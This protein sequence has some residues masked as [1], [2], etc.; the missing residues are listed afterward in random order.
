MKAVVILIC[1][2]FAANTVAQEL[3]LATEQQ[4]ENLADADEAATED[5]S[6]LQELE[7]FRR[8]PLNLN[9]TD[10]VALR[11]LR[12]LNELQVN[13]LVVYRN[14]FGRFISVYELQAIP[15]WD[16]ITI[17]KLLPFITTAVPFI[18]KEEW[19]KRLKEGE[20]SLILR[21]AQVLERSKGF[22]PADS[23]S[24]YMG[25][26]QRIFFR[27]RY[28]YKNLMQWGVTGDKDAGEQFGKGVQRFGFDFY[29]FHF[30]ARKLGLIESLA[31]GD[32]TVNMGQGL[33]H[34]Q[35]LAFKKSGDVMNVKRQSA[36]LRPYSSAGEFNFHRGA[37]ITLRKKKW[38]STL[39]ASF[40][41]LDGNI[42]SDSV[43][44]ENYV[45]SLISSGNHRTEAEIARR[46]NF[47]QTCLGA[48]V[49]YRG[50][51][52]HAGVNGL[53]YQFQFPVVKRDEP[54]N[55]YAING[56]RWS[57]FSVDYSYT[58]KNFHVFGEAATDHRFH[59]AFING[60]MIAVDARVDI[61]LVHRSISESYQSVNGNAFTENTYP[62][63]ETGFFMGAAIRPAAGWR[64]DLYADI[65]TFP[66]LR[67]LVDAPSQGK[68]FLVQL[69]Y[70]PNR[71]V[72]LF[73]RFR[74]EAKQKNQPGN[75]TTS[76]HIVTMPRQSWRTQVS[77]KLNSS[78]ALR[79][80][81]EILWHDHKTVNREMGF[82]SY[83][84][85]IYKP[86]LSSYS[87]IFRLQY[88]ETGGYNSRLY[89]YEN[90][91]L[92]GYSIPPF[93]GKGHRYYLLLQYDLSKK[94]A[95]WGR[96]GQTIFREGTSIGSG[97]DE[98]PGNRR[99]EIKVQARWLF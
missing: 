5:D 59:K 41:R 94:L 93:S 90:D 1:I 27:Y 35:S 60:L 6:Y 92:Y 51:N 43:N 99:T 81:I 30:F 19:K 40:R 3:P 17:K 15:G 73:T 28:V 86:L 42:V 36:A 68:E 49:I 52:W 16:I 82:L 33:I 75:T 64:I 67:Y 89:A 85:I 32:Y 21:V 65:Y 53:Y 88:F 22:D 55:L 69:T 2:V 71:H 38:E 50:H 80:R 47:K 78:F 34:W 48:S 95:F 76:H 12:I 66:W 18:V 8:H 37:A 31:I 29:S 91:V 96:W 56:D 70:T 83:I 23:G 58:Y 98:I 11:E 14:L 46:N 39:F 79:N 13:N 25:S 72:E 74:Q 44:E 97:R 84:D 61:S 10:A 7:H 9:S 87:G 77:Y 24:G 63:N 45:S 57:N 62:T 4:L 54:Y 26:P 20:H